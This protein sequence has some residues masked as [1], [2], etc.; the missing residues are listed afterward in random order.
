MTSNATS[1]LVYACLTHVPLWVE[2]PAYVT[3]IYLGDA[4][5]EGRLNLRDLAPEWV[6]HHPILGGAAGS[7]AL[8]NYLIQQRPD[9]THVGICQYRKFVSRQRISK[10]PV[11][12]YTSMDAVHKDRLHGA[13]FA[14]ALWPGEADFLVGTPVV[15]TK[16]PWYRKGYLKN[17]S[18]THNVEDFL[19][20]TA[21]AVE[22]GVLQR[23]EVLDFYRED[24]F[25][26]GG[27]ELGV[28]PADF[29]L[30]HIGQMEQVVRACIQR[31]PVREAGYQARAWAF[32]A[33]RLGSFLLLKR[34]RATAATG[35]ATRHSE[36]LNR[37]QWAGEFVG[38][39]NLITET[40][41]PGRYVGT[42]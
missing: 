18:R 29:W 3:P 30:H 10:L 13:A 40:A 2:F 27:I 12:K 7:F 9:A 14:Q 35:F 32:C 16:L 22:L 11:P 41:E 1:G 8:K 4:Q 23:A 21:Q 5:G 31:Y 20:F 24:V 6:P 17:Y 34:F 36:W 33:E 42:A 15:F 28:Y 39:I 38:K 26:P 19:R 37:R 25:I